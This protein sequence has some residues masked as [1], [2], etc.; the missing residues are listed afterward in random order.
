MVILSESI[1]TIVLQKL[2]H[3]KWIHSNNHI[4]QR[5]YCVFSCR[6]WLCLTR[7][8]ERKELICQLLLSS[9][10]FHFLNLKGEICWKGCNGVQPTFTTRCEIESLSNL[11]YDS[12]LCASTKKSTVTVCFLRIN[13]IL[14]FEI[15]KAL[16]FILNRIF[17]SLYCLLSSAL[18]RNGNL[19]NVVLY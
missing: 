5:M 16:G 15:V 18:V 17:L 1:V 8:A 12:V 9:W 7:L 13:T 19:G 6:L 4:L 10:I 14:Y 2:G 11:W 3:V